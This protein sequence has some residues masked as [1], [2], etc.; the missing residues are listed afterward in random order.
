MNT[1]KYAIIPALFLLAGCATVTGPNGAVNEP[2]ANT[3]AALQAAVTLADTAGYTF[4]SLNSTSGAQRA[5]T[6]RA[7]AAVNA[8]WSTLQKG[9]AAKQTV[10]VT[11]LESALS[12]LMAVDSPQI[13][14]AN[15][16][17]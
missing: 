3:M 17:R 12:A 1:K 10:D 13:V 8:A 6:I 16:A 2:T 11:G 5:A 7:V 9:V 4:E 14:Q 15:V